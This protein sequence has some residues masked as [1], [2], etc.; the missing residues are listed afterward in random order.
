MF[1]HL[2]DYLFYVKANLPADS[3]PVDVILLRPEA[4]KSVGDCL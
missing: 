1:A 2:S 4:A 3:T